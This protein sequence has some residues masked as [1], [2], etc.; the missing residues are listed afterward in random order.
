VKKWLKRSAP[1]LVLLAGFLIVQGLIA[2]KPEPEKKED[3]VRKVSLYVDEVRAE[4][5][6]VSVKTQGEVRPKTQIDVVPQVS[7][8]IVALSDSF[9]AGAEFLPDTMLLKIDDSDYRLAVINAEARVAEAQTALERELATAEIKEEEWRGERKK[10]EPTSFALNLTQVAEAEAKLR[11]R[12]RSGA[13]RRHR[14]VRGCRHEAGA[15]VLHRYRAGAVAADGC[16]AGGAESPAR[17]HG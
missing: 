7:G 6:V 4:D 12:P 11:S 15:R 10:Q 5:V 13:Q 1:V 8:R 2:A 14:P 16:A 17:L 9:N 3:E